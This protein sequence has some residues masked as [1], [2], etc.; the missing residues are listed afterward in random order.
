MPPTP[1]QSQARRNQGLTFIHVDFQHASGTS[2]AAH[3]QLQHYSPST[4]TSARGI[5]LHYIV[6]PLRTDSDARP[7]SGPSPSFLPPTTLPVP[8]SPVGLSFTHPIPPPSTHI[9][10]PPSTNITP[11]P[12][13]HPTPPP[14]SPLQ[15]SFPSKS[16]LTMGQ[17]L[18]FVRELQKRLAL[19]LW[20]QENEEIWEDCIQ[21]PSG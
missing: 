6:P 20:D 21:F 15:I 3:H 14:S 12:S 16:A 1:N 10:P 13:N 2:R 7:P 17:D 9:T 8:P 18:E 11:P 5:F 4:H 19:V